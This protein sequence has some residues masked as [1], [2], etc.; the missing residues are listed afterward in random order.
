MEHVDGLSLAYVRGL[1]SR[2]GLT[3]MPRQGRWRFGDV[4]LGKYRSVDNYCTVAAQNHIL[5]GYRMD[6]QLGLE[7]KFGKRSVA[8]GLGPG[9]QSAEI[10]VNRLKDVDIPIVPTD[11]NLPLGFINA[12]A[13]ASFFLLRGI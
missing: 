3:A 1:F 7:L 13:V 2:S 5:A 12:A 6:E 4:K 11:R 9:E 10:P 8:R